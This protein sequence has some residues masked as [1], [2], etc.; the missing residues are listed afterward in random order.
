MVV[1][2]VSAEPSPPPVDLR[3]TVEVSEPTFVAASAFADSLDTGP[4]LVRVRILDTVDL[5]IRLVTTGGVTLA[6]PPVPCLFWYHAAPD[7][8]GLESPCW[9][10]P[11]LAT[12][13]AFAPGPD[14]TWALDPGAA[15]ELRTSLSRGVGLC[16]YPP[17]EWLLRIR[18]VPLIDGQPG[19]PWYL[20]VPFEVPLDRQTPLPKVRLDESWFCG[21]ASEVVR[22]QGVPPTI[23]P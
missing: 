4:R 14:G 22:D 11:D 21:L 18:L 1:P 6:E 8:A 2:A 3:G 19:E 15:V 17:G 12:D 23:T 10:T 13:P 7:D 9:G 20:R 16:D 5:G